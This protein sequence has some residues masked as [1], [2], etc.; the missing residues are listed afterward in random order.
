MALQTIKQQGLVDNAG[1]LNLNGR[2]GLNLPLLFRDS[3][4]NPQ[5]VSAR[6]YYFEVQNRLRVQLQPGTSSDMQMLVLTQAQVASCGT[7]KPAFVLRD[8]TDTVP[9][10]KWEGLVLLRG[11]LTQPT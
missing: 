11:F 5:D 3:D 8:E 1:N 6:V 7:A 10:V 9:V 2:T 4:G